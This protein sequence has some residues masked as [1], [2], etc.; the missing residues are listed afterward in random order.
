VSAYGGDEEKP[1]VVALQRYSGVPNPPHT[2]VEKGLW[3]RF[4][5]TAMPWFAHKWELADRAA[6]A[7]LAKEVADAELTH[8]QALLTRAQAAQEAMKA[9]SM[10]RAMEAE[11]LADLPAAPATPEE[12]EAAAQAILAKV[13]ELGWKRG[14][15]IQIGTSLDNEPA[16][17]P[18][19]EG[20][21]GGEPG[22]D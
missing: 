17:P 13:A 7:R 3:R 8:A 9:I 10:A 16:L 6:D 5:E 15:R 18:P 20:A 1:E 12:L 22:E 21:V 14:T 2:P 19:A 11:K 4:L